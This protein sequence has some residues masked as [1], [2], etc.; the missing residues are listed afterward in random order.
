MPDGNS[1]VFAFGPFRLLPAERRLEKDGRPLRVG[2]RALDLLIV[3]VER[4]GEVV[5][6]HKLL[7][8]VWRDVNV[9][10]SSL[11]F[12]IKNLR[13]LLGD[14]HP[15]ARYVTNVPGRGYC[16][17]AP[18]SRTPTSR[19]LASRTPAG[20][21]MA[22]RRYRLPAF[23]TR[24][25]GRAS[26]VDALAPRLHQH[27]LLTISGPG[28]IGKSTVALAL[29]HARQAD[30][31]YGACF[32]DLAPLASPDLA[33]SAVA[34]ALGISP[35]SDDPISGLMGFLRH[36]RM[37]L[38]LDGCEHVIDEAALLAEAILHNAP[39]VRILATSREPL[40]AESEYV[41]R[42]AP[43]ELPADTARMTS[44]EALSF[45]AIQL[46]V[47]RAAMVLENFELTDADVPAVVDICRKLDG[48][49]L[50]IELATSRIDVLGVS[51]LSAG[52][53][54]RLQLLRYGRRTARDRHRTLNAA[55]AWSYD[56]LEPEEQVVL[57]RLA[58][59]AGA[60]D[61]AAAQ[62]V[63]AF[64]GLRAA[65]VVHHVANLATK[66]L[67]VATI[68]QSGGLYRLLDTTRAY[69]S[70]K[71]IAA[72]EAGQAA[73]RHAAWLLEKLP[74]VEREIGTTS[75]RSP[76]YNHRRLIDDVRAALDWAYSPSSNSLVGPTL[77]ANSVPLWLHL[78][79]VSE[80]RKWVEHALKCNDDIDALTRMRLMAARATVLHYT[81]RGTMPIEMKQAWANVL[82]IAGTLG[83]IQFSLRALWGLWAYG[84]NAERHSEMFTLAERFCDLAI[85]SNNP[86][87]LAT[88][89]RMLGHTLHYLG[90]Q[91]G[92]Q[93]HLERSLARLGSINHGTH[94][95]HFQY[96]QSIAARAYLPRTL[97]LLGFPDTAV[98]AAQ[99]LV[100]DAVAV[101]HGLSLCVAL[102][103]A[104]CPVALLVGDIEEAKRFVDLLL[105]TST[106]H[107]IDLWNAEGSCFQGATI[108]RGGNPQE[109][110]RILLNA[111]SGPPYM[112]ANVHRIEMLIE[113]SHAFACTGEFQ[114]ANG[115][116][117]DALVDSA[118]R[119]ERWCEAELLRMKGETL[120]NLE[121]PESEARAAEFFLQSLNVAREQGAL[122]W[123]LRSASSLARLRLKQ[124]RVSEGRACLE[125][126]YGRFKEGFQTGDLIAARH[127]LIELAV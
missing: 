107:S 116:L 85:R 4:A 5:P 54:D 82:E 60:F 31:E 33:P 27:G 29:A 102:A 23:S 53:G 28:G 40:R 88:G 123:E 110:Q 63:V 80:C 90:D 98:R 8:E 113:L 109:G 120:L 20:D 18:T 1:R 103:H 2:G 74:S 46:F 52:L 92:A 22:E 11:R 73:R 96:N 67:V 106:M 25:V 50:A 59:F 19:I 125:P 48:M 105:N 41:H 72:H 77:V 39:G 6:K 69:A 35:R 68:D 108:A 89:D 7:E 81:N 9:E 58:V 26:V 121:A 95:I 51:G 17:V 83:D 70:D 57:R 84:G 118:R 87:D 122:S 43:L 61:L 32:V 117:D 115:I 10:E 104:A 42:L 47:A 93:T 44:D 126:V 38:V 21:E 75:A 112:E 3:L 24:M 12:H 78:S 99:S 76:F 124:G 13:K 97:W 114:Q 37:L 34:S 101:G 45:S 14:N 94:S 65:T 66:S 15:D 64:K 86:V 91:A 56:F 36:R 55:L 111:M 79:L 71:L 62:S 119:D 49:P 127:L 100:E 16:F 30:Y